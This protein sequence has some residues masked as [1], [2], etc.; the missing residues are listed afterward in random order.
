MAEEE[1]PFAAFEDAGAA[2][3]DGFDMVAA[4]ADV[5][6]TPAGDGETPVEDFGLGG[7]AP[8][9]DAFGLGGDEEPA[10]GFPSLDGDEGLGGDDPAAAFGLG[11]AEAKVENNLGSDAF[12]LVTDD[13]LPSLDGELQVEDNSKLREWREQ[14]SIV[15]AERAS[16]ATTKKQ[17]NLETAKDET[18]DF[19]KQR[20][21][22]IARKAESNRADEKE[23]R[24]DIRST[25]QFGT[26]WEK[27]AKMVNTAPKSEK[28]KTDRMRKLLVQLKSEKKAN[29]EAKE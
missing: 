22:R 24:E 6:V 16:E 1:D 19:Y 3:D 9:A 26:E 25:M 28:A 15:L 18:A 11:D 5:L 7:E 8:G 27:V 4:E 12:G 17:A 21:A 20:E 29:V 2:P 13:P 23:Y 14:R 10:P